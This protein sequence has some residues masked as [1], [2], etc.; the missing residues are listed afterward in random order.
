MGNCVDYYFCCDLNKQWFMGHLEAQQERVERLAR[1]VD[2]QHAFVTTLQAQSLHAQEHIVELKSEHAT[3]HAQSEQLEAELKTR[4]AN[5]EAELQ[6]QREH[7]QGELQATVDH[8]EEAIRSKQAELGAQTSEVESKLKDLLVAQQQQLDRQK[9]Q[10]KQL[11][12]S[13]EEQQVAI[14]Q[15]VQEELTHR[16][17]QVIECLIKRFEERCELSKAILGVGRSETM[18]SGPR[19]QRAFGLHAHQSLRQRWL[20]SA[21]KPII[22]AINRAINNAATSSFD[23]SNQ[24]PEDA[25]ETAGGVAAESDIMVNKAGGTGE[26]DK[27]EL[28]AEMV[29]RLSDAIFS[30]LRAQERIQHDLEIRIYD[31]KT[32]FSNFH[33]PIMLQSR[34]PSVRL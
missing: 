11:E 10:L 32:K 28:W 5:S 19:G 17:K 30:R 29:T 33:R 22:K 4:C 13:F 16:F 23:D 34:M 1:Q 15:S 20:A 8:C 12:R 7:A 27:D 21:N 2:L 26:N 18:P 24:N 3:M 14:N 31:L 9:D 6:L 25:A